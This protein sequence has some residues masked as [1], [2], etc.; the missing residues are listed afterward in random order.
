MFYI[1]ECVLKHNG[2]SL[3][4]IEDIKSSIIT[5]QNNNNNNNNNNISNN[6]NIVINGETNING[7]DSNNNNN[8]KYNI[9]SSL[10]K[11]FDVT[12]AKVVAYRQLQQTELEISS[13]FAEIH[14]LLVVEEHKLKKPIVNDKDQLEQQIDNHVNEMKSLNHL[15]YIN[16]QFS[17]LNNNNNNKNKK[18]NNNDD[19]SSTS[20][21]TTTTTTTTS[22][23]TTDKYQLSNIIN[24]ISQSID[25]ND[26]IQQNIY[27]LFSKN[28]IDSIV[29]IKDIDIY[30]LLNLYIKHNA[31]YKHQPIPSELKLITNEK[32]QSFKLENVNQ[33]H[34]TPAVQQQSQLQSYIF[35][36]DK[37]R[38]AAIITIPNKVDNNDEYRVDYLDILFDSRWAYNSVVV[39]GDYIY[40][41]GGSDIPNNTYQLYSIK[42]R[43]LKLF[44]N[45][46]YSVIPLHNRIVRIDPETKAVVDLP[47]DFANKVV[48]SS[49][50]MCTD[51]VGNIYILSAKG[52]IRINVITHEIE[53]LQATNYKSLE[54][55]LVYYQANKDESYIYYLQGKD[56]NYVY[57]VEKNIW[58]TI[59]K[60][61]QSNRAFCASV[62]FQISNQ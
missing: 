35:S 25:S 10:Q 13:K 52:F 54:F 6:N 24:S 56:F 55:Q 44:G 50:A 51:G 58:Q 32:I 33:Q 29:S 45:Q 30:T 41:F 34:T 53:D 3:D 26:F 2:H 14:D 31:E 18:D 5:N 23:D 42:N 61:D 49:P 17:L 62:L 39:V 11:T 27:T 4:H 9:Q 8:I 7:S 20:L 12:K 37:E 43:L 15:N 57:S 16:N 19:N 28:N 36:T 22:S 47:I 1:F 21:T 59:M 40:R 48:L 38:R 46:M 60:N